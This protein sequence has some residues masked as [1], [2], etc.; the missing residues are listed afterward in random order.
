MSDHT[1]V[2]KNQMIQHSLEKLFVAR[3]YL[4]AHVQLVLEMYVWD[5]SLIPLRFHLLCLQAVEMA[6]NLG[7]SLHFVV[8]TINLG[9]LE[10][11]IIMPFMSSLKFFMACL[12]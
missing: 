10:N 12:F 2:N 8:T 7:S 9:P 4:S 5:F 1:D 3:V 11:V 6:Q